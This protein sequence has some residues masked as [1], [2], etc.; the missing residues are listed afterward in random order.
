MRWVN[1]E[2][3]TFAGAG[4]NKPAIVERME[5]RDHN[6]N[7]S[8]WIEKDV[9]GTIT[10]SFDSGSGSSDWGSI[11]GTLSDQTD[12]QSALDAKLDSSTV[13][14]ETAR[15]ALTGIARGAEVYQQDDGF[16]YKFIGTDPSDPMHWS[17][18]PKEYVA[19]I[20]QSGDGTSLQTSGVLTIGAKY[21]ITD[22]QSGDDFSNVANVTS[23]TVNT[24]GCVFIATGV[25]PA[26]YSNGSELRDTSAPISTIITNTLGVIPEWERAGAPGDPNTDY[27]FNAP[28]GTFPVGATTINGIFGQNLDNSSWIPFLEFQDPGYLLTK[29]WKMGSQFGSG[30]GTQCALIV[31]LADGSSLC[32]LNGSVMIHIRV[33]P[34]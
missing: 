29:Y 8:A 22:Y 4:G 16:F 15:L 18:I 28:I 26:D 20:T 11:G 7:V 5:L 31:L 9:T 24:T 6:E 12:L 17:A 25:T 33:C 34:S 27:N 13:A 23:G 10:S 14:D 2:T 21:E 3:P 19:N 32:D 1:V 30:D